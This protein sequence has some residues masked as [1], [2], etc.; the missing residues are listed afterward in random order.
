MMDDSLLDPTGAKLT[1]TTMVYYICLLHQPMTYVTSLVWLPQVRV[2]AGKQA[3]ENRISLE[4]LL[5]EK[6]PLRSKDKKN[7]GHNDSKDGS[8]DSKGDSRIQLLLTKIRKVK[9]DI[10]LHTNNRDDIRKKIANLEVS[11][12][13]IC[14]LLISLKIHWCCIG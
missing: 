14:T 2:G 8:S 4:K 11:I 10:Q 9:E 5:E 7:G 3:K 13:C 6:F 12:H 1:G